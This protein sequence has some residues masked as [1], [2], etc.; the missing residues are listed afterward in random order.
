MPP[1]DPFDY[2][3]FDYPALDFDN[4]TVENRNA[5]RTGLSLPEPIPAKMGINRYLNENYNAF[6]LAKKNMMLTSSLSKT[7]T[8]VFIKTTRKLR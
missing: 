1:V 8:R 7:G 6:N 2:T 3:G 5:T 4:A